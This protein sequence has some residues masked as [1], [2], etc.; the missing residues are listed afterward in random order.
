M[1]ILLTGKHGQVGFELQRALAPLGEVR[2]VDYTECD[3]SDAAALCELIQSVKP[4]LIVNSAAY[5][6]VDRAES[7][8]ELAR[9]VNAVAPGVLGEEAAKRGAWIIHYSTDYVFDGTKPGAYIEDDET[10]PLSVY[11]QT[12]RS[13]EIA[14]EES[15]VPYLILRTSW[16][17]GAHGNNFAKTILRLASERKSLNVVGDQHGA[18]TSA[19]L[20]ADVTAHLVW[21]RRRGGDTN[22]PY[23]L[24]HLAA[25]GETTWCEYARFIVA[26]TLAAGRSLALSSDEIRGITSSD[27]PTVAKRPANSRLDTG[28]LRKTFDLELPNWQS[29]VRHVLQQI[30]R[31]S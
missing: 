31:E 15:G 7:E 29:G 21:Q 25:S 24:Y 13:G 6:A 1:R 3:L 16:V 14:L 17:V 10:N 26:E 11:G 4:D 23:G 8:P 19:A 20:L 30:L 22:F 2:A 5:T 28:K 12:K 27:Y 18:P 9:A